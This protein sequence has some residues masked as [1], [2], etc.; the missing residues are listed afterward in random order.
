MLKKTLINSSLSS[1]T[2]LYPSVRFI[3][4]GKTKEMDRNGYDR[5]HHDSMGE[6]IGDPL[7]LSFFVEMAQDDDLLL[8]QDLRE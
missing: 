3:C 4:A 7:Q 5:V 8:R 1:V 6:Q 2:V